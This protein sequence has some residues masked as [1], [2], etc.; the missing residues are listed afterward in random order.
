MFE[1]FTDRARRAVVLAQEEARLLNHGYIGSEHLLLGLVHEGEGVAFKALD[2]LG[3]SKV[4]VRDIIL[5]LIGEGGSAP[6]GHIPFTPRCK[7]VIEFSLREAL[8]LGHNYVGTEHLLLG[9]IREGEGVGIQTLVKLNVDPQVVRKKVIEILAGY[10]EAQPARVPN[11][12]ISP[13]LAD[14]LRKWIKA[15]ELVQ[16]EPLPAGHPLAQLRK[17][18]R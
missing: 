15:F 14:S 17:A 12:V 10:G 9:L 16:G 11:V 2:D 5:E 6:A 18:M 1:R 13:L 3:V 7:K 4:A 8:Q